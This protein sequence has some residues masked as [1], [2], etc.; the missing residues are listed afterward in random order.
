MTAPLFF[1][2]KR[3]KIGQLWPLNISTFIFVE[4]IFSFKDL[5]DLTEYLCSAAEPLWELLWCPGHGDGLPRPGRLLRRVRD[6]GHGARHPRGNA[7]LG[8]SLGKEDFP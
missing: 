7:H 5:M 4:C 6:P 8:S 3:I 1:I 2:E